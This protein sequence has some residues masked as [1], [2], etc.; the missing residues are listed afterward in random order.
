MIAAPPLVPLAGAQ[1]VDD[2]NGS[3]IKTDPQ[4]SDGWAF[5]TGD[6]TATMTFQQ[7]GE[8]Y[9]SIR[10]DA[11]TDRRGIW[12]ALIKHKVSERMDLQ[13]LGPPGD[14]A[15]HRGAH[16]CQPR[17]ASGEPAPEHPA[18]HGL[19]QPSDGVRHP[20]QRHLAHHQH[21]HARL[22]CRSGRHGIRT[23]GADRLG[24]REV[25]GGRRLLQ[26][27]HRRRHTRRTRQRR[28]RPLSSA[29]SRS[30]DVP[31]RSAERPG[32]RHRSRQPGRESEQLVRPGRR[33]EEAASHGQR[34]AVRDPAL[35][36]QLVRRD[37]RWRTTGCSSSPPIPCKERRT[38]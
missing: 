28:C 26:G 2:F 12:W 37:A 18:D 30:E 5:R 22:P 3:S 13:Q 15:A 17:A 1:F 35:R 10:V 31:A 33:R 4:G 20:R 14:G 23:D 38:R 24:P 29:N 25:P 34:H 21:D 9:A 27:G 7:G 36:S 11:T 32:R 6:G 19:S 16:P 8:G